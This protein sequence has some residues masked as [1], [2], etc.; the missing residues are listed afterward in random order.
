MKFKKQ[1]TT[2]GLD[3]GQ[4]YARLVKLKRSGKKFTVERAEEL[5]IVA[6]G[7][8]DEAELFSES[9]IG[10]WLKEKKLDNQPIC[11]GLPQYLCTTRNI[12]DF[13][14]NAKQEQ[15]EQM[16]QFETTQLAGLSEET[17]ISD[18]QKMTPAYGIEAPIIIGFGREAGSNEMAE[19]CSKI[20]VKLSDLAMGSFALA[21]AFCYLHPEELDSDTI[22]VIIDLGTENSTIVIMAHGNVV[23]TGSLMFGGKR[24]TQVLAATMECTEAE[25][26]KLKQNY[27]PDWNDNESPYIFATRQLETELRTSIDN[28]RSGEIQ[29]LADLEISKMWLCGGAARTIGLAEHLQRIYGCPVE[30]L[31]PSI[32]RPAK[33]PKKDAPTKLKLDKTAE[34]PSADQEKMQPQP[35]EPETPAVPDDAAPKELAP[36]SPQT[37]DHDEIPEGISNIF[38]SM[39]IKVNLPSDDDS[40]D[41]TAETK[42]T[43][44][45]ETSTESLE[46]PRIKVTL[47]VQEEVAPA[48]PPI[49]PIPSSKPTIDL[50]QTPKPKVKATSSLDIAPEFTLAF[51]L[52]LQTTGN[53]AY[54][55]SLAPLL[56]RWQIQREDRLRYLIL[57]AFFLL[58]TIAGSMIAADLWLNTHI[59]DLNEG[60]DELHECDKLVPKLDDAIAQIEYQQKLLL[61]F[62][63]LG[64]R[65][66]TFSK[67]LTVI[68][69]S[70]GPRDWCFY[71]ADQYSYAEH[72]V[73]PQKEESKRTEKT[74]RGGDMF[75][76]PFEPQPEKKVDL[77]DEQ[78]VVLDTMPLI[79]YMVMAGYTPVENNKRYAGVVQ[80]QNKLRSSGFFNDQVDTMEVDWQ[81]NGINLET[82]WNQ[83]LRSQKSQLGEFTE[84][85]LT[86][87][88]AK[89]QVDI[90]PPKE[91][92]KKNKKK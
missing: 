72:N 91:Q 82:G 49:E 14:A 29:A 63:E 38:S 55:I 22:Q 32:N 26:E 74:P 54:P 68:N 77:K 81:G 18:Y 58:A 25:A 56:R 11:F 86:L 87:P 40:S 4:S 50:S 53:A 80:L 17:F 24:F 1:N 66:N 43:S 19:K 33:S 31:G 71:F 61:P 15:L 85:K 9:G 46:L 37:E 83:Y 44:D 88:L 67:A 3:V 39:K 23:Y 89:K 92:P 70:K 57:A 52:A 65:V 79:T 28:W 64:G 20:P 5:D 75:G 35:A 16:V 6:E 42:D 13:K 90:P 27:V 41:S 45:G 84:F 34:T 21:N 8:L 12:N 10:K 30:L 59:E 78:K 2:L 76:S 7:I 62:V 51:G 48:E 36:E 47:P 60:M 73:P 69:E